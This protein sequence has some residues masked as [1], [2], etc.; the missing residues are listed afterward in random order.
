MALGTNNWTSAP[1]K[2]QCGAPNFNW[3][4][5]TKRNH[6][7][8]PGSAGTAHIYRDFDSRLWRQMVLLKTTVST[9]SGF[10]INL[11]WRWFSND[12]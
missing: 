5:N 3:R 6:L 11:R 4:K 7:A 1:H 10:W 8:N 2:I 9:C 12:L